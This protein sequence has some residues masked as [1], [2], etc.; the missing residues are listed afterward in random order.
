VPV[1]PVSGVANAC[2]V[3]QLEYQQFRLC[4]GVHHNTVNN[5]RNQLMIL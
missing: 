3:S 2:A 1:H 5:P 4:S